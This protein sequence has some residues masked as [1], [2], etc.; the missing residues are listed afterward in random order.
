MT[1][2]RSDPSLEPAQIVP[3]LLLGP[4]PSNPHPRVLQALGAPL[5]SHFD[6]TFHQILDELAERLRAVFRSRY[7]CTLAV[8][9][10]GGAGME[11]VLAS[12]LAPADE[13][14]VGIAGFFGARIAE[15]AARHEVKVRRLEVPWGQA[16]E[17]DQVRAALRARRARAL[18]LV[19]GETSTGMLQPLEAIARI[20][21]EEETWLILDTVTT[22]G[23]VPLDIERLGITASFSCSQKCLGCPPGLAPVTVSETALQTR[24]ASSSWYLDL[25]AMERYWST[26]RTYHHTAPISMLY[27]LHEALGLVLAEGVEQQWQRHRL[28]GEALQA[29]L[30]ALGL[31]LFADPAVRLPLVTAVRVPEGFDDRKVRQRL[32]DRFQMEIGGG[33]GPLAGQIWRI[34]LMGYGSSV[35]HVLLCLAA[36]EEALVAQGFPAPR[37]AGVA[38][39]EAWLA[40]AARAT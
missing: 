3:R 7:P 13:V 2:A 38:A 25:R 10:S 6:A 19:H 1:T 26:D 16:L 39:A 9:G 8:T 31:T 22:L 36:L 21:A 40:D 23:G 5:M 37:G 20:A 14:V 34:G 15:A 27:A 11:A 35:N 29:G 18:C 28:H 30:E 32:L 33:L 12:L 17:P 24:P 4:G